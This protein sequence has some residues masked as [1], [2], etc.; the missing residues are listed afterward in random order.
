MLIGIRTK[1]VLVH[2]WCR[3]DIKKTSRKHDVINQNETRW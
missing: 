1:I 3:S 2:C